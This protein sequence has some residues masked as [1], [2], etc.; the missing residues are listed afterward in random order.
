MMSA[1]ADMGQCAARGRIGYGRRKE[2]REMTIFVCRDSLEGILCG[3]Y[4]AWMS[5][6]GHDNVALELEDRG[7]LQMFCQYRQVEETR[8]KTDKVVDAIRT[9]AGQDA[10]EMVFRVSLSR[11][12]EKADRI[13]RFLIYALNLKRDVTDL[14]QIPAVYE[15]FRINRNVGNEAHLL[16]EFA[17]FSRTREGL[18]VCTVGPKNDVII[19]MAPHFADRLP[20]ENWIIYDEGR[21]KAIVHKADEGWMVVGTDLTQWK[22]RLSDSTDQKEFEELWKAFHE[23]IAIKER[24]NYVCQRGH[25]PLRFRPYMTEFQ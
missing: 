17:R 20:G 5:R 13:Y 11:E 10:Y 21:Q 12:E 16:I 4:D 8:E 23:T 18:L 9:K 22:E 1:F 6:L 25:L 7:N 14:L 24:T 3:V 2:E 15:V 19:L